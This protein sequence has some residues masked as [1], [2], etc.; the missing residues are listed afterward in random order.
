MK[1]QYTVL[2][3]HFDRLINGGFP[4]SNS[5]EPIRDTYEE[6]FERKI[7]LYDVYQT[8]I[9]ISTNPINGII[10]LIG[11]EDDELK[12][13]IMPNDRDIVSVNVMPESILKGISEDMSSWY[14]NKV[15]KSIQNVVM[16]DRFFIKSPHARLV[17]NPFIV[18]TKCIS[19]YLTFHH[20]KDSA[21]EAFDENIFKD[22]LCKYIALDDIDVDKIY[23]STNSNKYTDDVNRIYLIMTANGTAKIR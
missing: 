5:L 8:P 19:F 13:G 22:I 2:K 4:Y 1:T 15:Y 21:P 6:M 7:N 20:I 12:E 3:E 18:F 10:T 9:K 23:E 14:I 16:V 11:P 17:D